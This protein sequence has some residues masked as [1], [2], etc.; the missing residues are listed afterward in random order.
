MVLI[1]RRDSVLPALPLSLCKKAE[2]RELT[3]SLGLGLTVLAGS[4]VPVYTENVHLVYIV[5]AHW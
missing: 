4:C 5:N 3:I 2:V 1:C